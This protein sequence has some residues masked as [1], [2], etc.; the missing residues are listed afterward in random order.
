VRAGAAFPS[1]LGEMGRTRAHRALRDAVASKAAKRLHL[2]REKSRL[3]VLSFLERLL[4]VGTETSSRSEVRETARALVRELD[5]TREEVAYLVGG[6]P[7][8]P[9]VE[10]LFE[11]AERPAS[12]APT[13]ARADPPAPA[14]PPADPLP[15]KKVQRSL[16][17]FTS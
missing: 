1:F 10:R 17:E 14:S 11:P 5:L 16:A 7:E 3:Y 4:G 8:S 15:P 12:P 13:P 2:S 9:R 6:E